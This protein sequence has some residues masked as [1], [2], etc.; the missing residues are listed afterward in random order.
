MKILHRRWRI[1]LTYFHILAL[2]IVLLAL[3]VDLGTY[4]TW[5]EVSLS[6]LSKS[7]SFLVI[8]LVWKSFAVLQLRV[9]DGSYS[10]LGILSIGG[11]GGIL[12]GSSLHAFHLVI[13]LD[14]MTA[15]SNFI[16]TSAIFA[17]IWLPA[18][19]LT[20]QSYTSFRKDWAKIQDLTLQLSSIELARERLRRSQE[21]LLKG[22]ISS[23]L[24]DSS[25]SAQGFLESATSP[26]STISFADAARALATDHLRVLSHNILSLGARETRNIEPTFRTRS[27]AVLIRALKISVSSRPLDPAIFTLAT[28]ATVSLPILRH[29]QYPTNILILLAI[30]I[31]TYG[32]QSLGLLI[33]SRAKTHPFLH[34]LTITILNVIVTRV[35]IAYLPGTALLTNGPLGVS[36]VLIL[37]TIVGLIA[38]TGLIRREEFIRNENE[39]LEIAKQESSRINL[40]LAAITQKWAE[41]IHGNLQSKLHAYALVLEQAELSNDSERIEIA[42]EDI[43]RVITA[44]DK[45]NEGEESGTLKT[46]ISRRIEPWSGLV[47]IKVFYED[48]IGEL[49]IPANRRLG[50]CVNEAITNAVRHGEASKI[51]ISAKLNGALLNLTVVDNGI[52]FSQPV[53]GLG[54][55]VFDAATKRQ[56][57]LERNHANRETELYL[58]FS[59][60]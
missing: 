39:A 19:S 37:V 44:L 2:L 33:Y 12:Q 15:T 43:R 59:I 48:P 31:T 46:E 13:G 30:G 38:Q 28:L 41:H 60:D 23:M 53:L 36:V 17:A 9:G 56:W 57:K 7:L 49:V 14:D 3:I 20:V 50:D 35:V 58:S 32:V 34:I 4:S 18:H 54:S 6:A 29:G 8:Y 5:R 10:S 22:K 45:E 25:K 42:V 47:E 16:I 21:E 11:L 1:D 40:E 52:G 24:Q 26:E 55:K 51:L 27:W